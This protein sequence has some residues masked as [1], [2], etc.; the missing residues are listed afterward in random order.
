MAKKKARKENNKSNFK[1]TSEEVGFVDKYVTNDRA[2]NQRFNR[3]LRQQCDDDYD[4]YRK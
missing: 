1:Y 3:T 2:E 4:C